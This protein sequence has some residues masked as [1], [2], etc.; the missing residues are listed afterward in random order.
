MRWRDKYL[1]AWVRPSGEQR[2]AS[3]EQARRMLREALE[4]PCKSGCV[5]EVILKDVSTVRNEPKRVWEWAD[6]AMQVVEEFA[7]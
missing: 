5:V 4:K 6:L 2:G 1:S 7:P 3:P